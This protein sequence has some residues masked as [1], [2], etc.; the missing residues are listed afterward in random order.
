MATH[1]ILFSW[2][3]SLPVCVKTSPNHF[4]DFVPYLGGM[5]QNGTIESF[6]PVFMTPS[7]GANMGGFFLILGA[8]DKLHGMAESDDWLGHITRANVHL[9]GLALLQGVTGDELYRRFELWSQ[10]VES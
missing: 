3:R 9:Q 7:G 4:V 10:F 8:G 1:T 5:Q 2:Q 6:V